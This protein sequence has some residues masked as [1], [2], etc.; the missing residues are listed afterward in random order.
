MS[1]LHIT[2]TTREG[3]WAPFKQTGKR[4]RR[5]E[6][7][8]NA[9]HEN[10]MVRATAAASP[11]ASPALLRS[12]ACDD[13]PKVREWVAR[14]TETPLSVLRTLAYTEEHAPIRAFVAWNPNV[15][16]Q[17]LNFLAQDGDP[18]VESVAK[19]V[20]DSRSETVLE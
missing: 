18:Q 20:L 15:D 7:E 4:D 1:C 9:Q 19:M 5:L 17:T 11:H 6:V 2:G 8:R 13:D 16:E 3:S 14:N 12:L 10:P